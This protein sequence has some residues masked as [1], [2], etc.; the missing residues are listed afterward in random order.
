MENKVK[1][2]RTAFVSLYNAMSLS[3]VLV[4]KF[5]AEIYD[6]TSK[7]EAF[8]I[9]EIYTSLFLRLTKK[10]DKAKPETSFTMSAA[11]SWAFERVL[12]N[13]YMD[14]PDYERTIIEN[15]IQQIYQ[16]TA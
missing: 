13:I 6:G 3:M 11:E 1:L 9:K 2:T 10:I 15:I 8:A 12:S 7:P 5:N 16:K 4:R 14:L